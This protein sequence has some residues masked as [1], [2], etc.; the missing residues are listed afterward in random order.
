[1]ILVSSNEI[2]H[3]YL[4]VEFGLF[5]D[6]HGLH[7]LLTSQLLRCTF[8]LLKILHHS[9]ILLSLLVVHQIGFVRLLL[10]H[11]ADLEELV[12]LGR[13][14]DPAFRLPICGFKNKLCKFIGFIIA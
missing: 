1:M 14:V 2:I 10:L 6:H 13:N 7:A 12:K 5:H 9:L 4:Y 8:S 3:S 11:L